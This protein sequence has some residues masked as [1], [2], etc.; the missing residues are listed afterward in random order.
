MPNVS[1]AFLVDDSIMISNISEITCFKLLFFILG[2]LMLIQLINIDQDAN[3]ASGEIT[4][5][6]KWGSTCL[7]YSEM[8]CTPDGSVSQSR[9]EG[10]FWGLWGI[11]SD[12]FSI[13]ALDVLNHRVQKFDHNGQFMSK[14]GTNGTGEGQFDFP[15]GIAVDSQYVYVTD[16][17]NRIQI[18][19]KQGQFLKT[20]GEAG[21]DPGQ[22]NKPEDI[23]VD[24][25]GRIYV[26]DSGNNRIQVFNPDLTISNVWGTQGTGNGQFDYPQGIAVPAPGHVYVTDSHNNRIQ[27]FQLASPCPPETT[28]ITTNVCLAKEWGIKGSAD[29]EFSRPADIDVSGQFVYVVDGNNNRVQIFTTDGIFV[30]KF[31]TECLIKE[32]TEPMGK[33]KDPDGDG[34][35]KKGD[36]QFKYPAGITVRS[37]LLFIA[38]NF[39]DRIQKLSADIQLPPVTTTVPIANAG[40]DQTVSSGQTVTL[41]G[42]RSTPNDGSLQFLWRQS[43]GPEQVGLANKE[44]SKPTFEAPQVTQDSV[45]EFELKVSDQNGHSDIDGISVKIGANQ[46]NQQNEKPKANAGPEKTVSEGESTELDGDSSTDNDGSIEKYEWEAG[47]CDN[48]EPKGSVQQQDLT[49]SKAR[50]VAPQISSSSTTCE[51]RLTVT[52]NDGEKD[53]DTVQITVNEK[54]SSPTTGPF[55]IGPGVKAEQ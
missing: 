7:I 26:A 46:Q 37:N 24:T 35:L 11:A 2:S 49:N 16:H 18:F 55:N 29:G 4:F 28:E 43:G 33:C 17:G 42:E 10:Q 38:D 13:Y 39:N 8:S 12:D 41:D 25:D 1:D 23:D 6:D 54:P 30:D 48:N 14:W 19:D 40:I 20:I 22:F 27:Y 5:L 15:S 51:V 53:S 50:F 32:S 47:D 34:P 3:G 52:D 36:G 45:F 31:G 21:V 9:G 44:T